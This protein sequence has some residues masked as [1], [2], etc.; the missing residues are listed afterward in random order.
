MLRAPKAASNLQF[1]YTLSVRGRQEAAR[2]KSGDPVESRLL[3][4]ANKRRN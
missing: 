1:G 4:V 2:I 3:L